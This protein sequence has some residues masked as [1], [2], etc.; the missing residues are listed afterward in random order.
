MTGVLVIDKPAGW[1]SFDVIA[2]LRGVLHVQ[3]MGHT[4]TLDPMA[5]GVLPVFIS[6]EATKHIPE[7]E[8][9]EKEYIAGLRLGVVTDTLDTTGTI[10]YDTPTAIT[11][12]RLEAALGEFRGE[13]SQKPP[14]FSAVKVDGERLYKIAR[15][16]GKVETPARTVTVFA[17]E[18]L[19]EP[20]DQPRS[21]WTLRFHVSKGTYIRALCADIGA[22]IG[23]G[24]VMF[25]LRRTRAGEF[26]L[27]D[28]MTLEQAL[29]LADEGTLEAQLK[30]IV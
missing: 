2:K 12:E 28:A 19:D 29:R 11:R 22:A 21:D 8:N 10:I 6:R 5:T 3:K 16:G 25:S 18:I 27:K 26:T 13:I 14:M 1:T 4:G 23:T 15:R 24:G 20:D 30:K 17:A 7:Y 9:A